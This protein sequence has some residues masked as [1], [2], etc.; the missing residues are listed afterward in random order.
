MLRL[1]P[2]GR[3]RGERWTKLLAEFALLREWLSGSGEVVGDVGA[4]RLRGPRVVHAV[5]HVGHV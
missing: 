1:R 3:E 4:V 5:L 2:C